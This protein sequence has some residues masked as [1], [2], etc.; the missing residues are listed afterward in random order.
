VARRYDRQTIRTDAFKRTP[1]GSLVVEASLTRAGVFSYTDADGKVYREYRP[2]DELARAESLASLED[3][4]VT[5]GHPRGGVGPES[6]AQLS[7]GHV[8]AGSPKADGGVVAGRLVIAR[9]D[10][11]EG[12]ASGELAETSMGYDCD[13]VD[14]PGTAPDGTAYDRVQRNYV[15]NHIALLRRG[16]SRLGTKLRLDSRGDEVPETETEPPKMKIKYKKVDGSE[17]EIVKGSDEHIALIEAERDAA[18]ADSAKASAELARRD[19]EAARTARTALESKAK[20]LG[21]EVK[22]DMSDRDLRVAAITKSDPAF[23]ADGKDDV[24]VT[25]RFDML[26]ERA[27]APKAGA[28][29][30]VSGALGGRS[31]A[32]PPKEGEDEEEDEEA[33]AKKIKADA[34]RAWERN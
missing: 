25:V 22:A 13:V 21:V 1:A 30:V 28:H 15:W 32:F 19:A 31:D 6:Y 29:P 18:R 26:T 14:E 7:A 5:I 23:K 9:K 12:V 17:V 2:A 24:Y 10:A 33:K 11:I 3:V 34:L 8:R 16:D 20:S 4:S 27:P